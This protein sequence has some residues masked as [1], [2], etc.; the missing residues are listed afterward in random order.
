[1]K[2]VI[3]KHWTSDDDMNEMLTQEKISNPIYLFLNTSNNR[4]DDKV[5]IEKLKSDFPGYEGMIFIYYCDNPN[6]INVND[7]DLSS[8]ESTIELTREGF[9]E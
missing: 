5:K 9:Y 2:G 6:E 4:N 3:S 7:Y 8:Y 1:M